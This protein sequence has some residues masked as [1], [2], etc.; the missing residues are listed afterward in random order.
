MTTRGRGQFLLFLGLVLSLIWI[1]GRPASVPDRDHQF[2]QFEIEVLT[3][4]R[5][6]GLGIHAGSRLSGLVVVQRTSTSTRVVALDLD[7]VLEMGREQV[8][9]SVPRGAWVEVAD[10]EVL[11]SSEIR[12]PIADLMRRL[13]NSTPPTGCP[14]M[15]STPIGKL[16]VGQVT[17][18][19]SS[20]ATAVAWRSIDD[21]PKG[22]GVAALGQLEWNRT[23]EVRAWAVG[24][25][26]DKDQVREDRAE[27]TWRRSG[28]ADAPA[29]SED[30]RRVA[31]FEAIIEADSVATATV[32]SQEQA[33]A[34]ISWPKI[35]AMLDGAGASTPSGYEV[36]LFWLATEHL[37]LHPE[38][39]PQLEAGF[40]VRRSTYH[41]ELLAMDLLASTGT[42]EAQSVL[43]TVL[44][45]MD[46][47][48]LLERSFRR[49]AA[50]AEPT[51]ET[52]QSL[53]R[54][55]RQDD[56]NLKVWTAATLALGVVAGRIESSTGERTVI[57]IEERIQGEEA[58][59]VRRTMLMA[60][61]NARL[62][63]SLPLL[64]E[65]SESE[66]SEDR[67]GV[68]NALRY[69]SAPS[70]LDLLTDLA[71]DDHRR[72][73][74]QAWRGIAEQERLP[75]AEVRSS[76]YE[77]FSESS[78]RAEN[79]PYLLKFMA[80]DDDRGDLASQA[81]SMVLGSPQ[82]SPEVRARLAQFT[83]ASGL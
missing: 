44:D 65:L 53:S 30:G 11:V 52:L 56:G 67:Y 48:R 36:E 78:F 23:G 64:Q 66:S 32:K 58:P 59:F 10:S 39:L 68:A 42:P 81:A 27:W 47:N 79:V 76:L 13:G 63:R 37:R 34:R 9:L 12:G 55:F 3:N 38:L 15:L 31:R 77:Q 19:E 4:T 41:W 7:A 35:E 71:H 5:L 50:V 43:T 69:F 1:L 6:Q 20:G 54:W 57:E 80:R 16:E 83:K 40:K 14:S 62:E 70:A 45:G 46:D 21:Y 24:R 2:P 26:Q 49:F 8:E 33:A 72:V 74:H 29:T 60:L 73:A 75:S 22:K 28:W 61:G 25:G 18:G 82:T 17:C 51:E